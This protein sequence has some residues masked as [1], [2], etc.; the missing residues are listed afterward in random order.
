LERASDDEGI[1]IEPLINHCSVQIYTVVWGRRARD[2]K[3]VM[4][5]NH[6]ETT[7][8][9]QTTVQFKPILSFGGGEQEIIKQ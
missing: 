1:E 8:Q 7:V 6:Y 9:L 4:E 3:A 2:Y 5:I